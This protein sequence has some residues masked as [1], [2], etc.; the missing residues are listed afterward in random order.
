MTTEHLTASHFGSS[1]FGSSRFFSKYSLLPREVSFSLCRFCI[2]D[3]PRVMPRKGWRTMELPAGWLQVLRGPRL[4]PERWP[5]EVGARRNLN[6][7]PNKETSQGS[8]RKEF[9]A[10]PTRRFPRGEDVLGCWRAI[11]ALGED[12]PAVTGLKEALRQARSQA[13]VRPVDDV[14]K[15]TKMFIE[16]RQFWRHK[17]S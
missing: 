11:N 6:V 4:P 2:P 9:P 5:M 14:I 12:D 7:E 1:H 3:Q 8:F 17:G 13:Q 15:A 10:T 16:K